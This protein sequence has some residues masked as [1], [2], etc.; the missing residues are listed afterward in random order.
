M[1]KKGDFAGKNGFVVKSGFIV[2]IKCDFVNWWI[3]WIQKHIAPIVKFV[4]QSTLPLN[5]L[6]SNA[7][8]SSD[9]DWIKF[10]IVDW[11]P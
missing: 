2:Q 7:T 3:S 6:R 5:V 1:R 11:I 4:G 9:K 8:T 10:D